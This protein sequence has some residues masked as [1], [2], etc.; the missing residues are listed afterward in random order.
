MAL[1]SAVPAIV[2]KKL[3][4]I[5]MKQLD[6]LS[7]IGALIGNALNSLPT[8]VKCTDPRIRDIKQK[9]ADVKKLLDNINKI[10]PTLQN[11]VNTLNVI[12]VSAEI[13]KLIQLVIPAVL[14]VPQVPFAM[15]AKTVDELGK[16]CKS[17]AMALSTIND[18]L[19]ST[20]GGIDSV[21][22]QAI[23]KLSTVCTN[24]QF[25]VTSNQSKLIANSS[26]GGTVTDNRTKVGVGEDA[27]NNGGGSAGGSAGGGAG[28]GGTGGAGG[29]NTYGTYTSY[30]YTPN[31]VDSSDIDNVRTLVDDLSKSVRDIQ[32]NLIEFP[33]N[34][35]T[36]AVLNEKPKANIGKLGDFYVNTADQLIYGPKTSDD[37]W[38]SISPTKY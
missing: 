33:S 31:N 16:N 34:V 23:I 8:G 24:E 1:S 26:T 18:V 14:G 27:I 35:I 5:V 15:V 20:I 19:N 28:V 17:A 21:V 13:I 38:P 37:N 11:I 22:A 36:S 6:Q 2:L 7:N 25:S 9:L 29:G 32:T 4:P 3:I 10:K 12:Q 30:F